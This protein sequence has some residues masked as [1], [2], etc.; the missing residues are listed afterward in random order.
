MTTLA[1]IA[2][3]LAQGLMAVSA[4]E[5]WNGIQNL[6]SNTG[7]IS[8]GWF[9]LAMALILAVSIITFV[10]VHLIKKRSE[11]KAAEREFAEGVAKRQLTPAQTDTLIEIANRAGLNRM[12]DIFLLSDTFET[13]LDILF[14]ESFVDG[15]PTDRTVELERRLAELKEKMNFRKAAKGGGYPGGVSHPPID[16]A[17]GGELVKPQAEQAANEQQAPALLLGVNPQADAGLK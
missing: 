16:H 11:R 4:R 10:A 8:S 9:K 15:N 13:G 6:K 5:R 12:A 7:F 14:K 17:R 2:V 3:H 1:L